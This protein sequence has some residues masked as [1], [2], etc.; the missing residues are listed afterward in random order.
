MDDWEKFNKEAFPEKKEFYNNLNLEHI[1]E[2]NCNYEKR[3]YR[4]F[5]I[6]NLGQCHDLYIRSDVLLL[7]DVLENFQKMRF[8]N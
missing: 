3:I 2:E 1:S 7:A 8:I 6:K 4:D 5:E